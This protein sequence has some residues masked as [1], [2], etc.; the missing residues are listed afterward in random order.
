MNRA[1]A[2]STMKDP[3]RNNEIAEVDVTIHILSVSATLVGV[4]LTVI[5][6]FIMS[7]RLSHVKSFGEK[8]LAFD[9]LF[10]LIRVSC[11]TYLSGCVVKKGNSLSS[12]LP[13]R[14][15]CWGLYSWDSS[16]FSSSMSLLETW[17]QSH[18]DNYRIHTPGLTGWC[19]DWFNQHWRRSDHCPCPGI[20]VR[21][22]TANGAGHDNCSHGPANRHA[23][24]LDVLSEGL[25]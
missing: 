13:K 3:N 21:S 6:I 24:R 22:F 7:K 8:L 14:Y 19:I 1:F 4:C 20:F 5:G 9:A 25:C 2:N 16:V 12:G 10:F 17:R 11:H 15:F 23:G 18:C